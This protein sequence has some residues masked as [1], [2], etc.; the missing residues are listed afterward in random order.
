MKYVLMD[1]VSD[2][3]WTNLTKAEQEQWLG[4]Y[5]AYMQAM[6]TAGVLKEAKGLVP[7]SAATTVRVV[8]GKTQVLDGPYADRS[9]P[10][11]GTR[12][13]LGDRHAQTVRIQHCVAGRLLHRR[14][15]RHELGAPRGG[16][17]RVQ[18][19]HQRE[20]ERRWHVDIR[21]HYLPAHGV[22]L[23][24]TAGGETVPCGRRTNERAA[25]GRVLEIAG[26]GRLEQHEAGQERSGS[27][28]PK[29]EERVRTRH[30][31]H[32]K[33]HDRFATH[34]GTPDR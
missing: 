19:I 18:R 17:C 21:S 33:R 23:A 3:G 20:R 16:R 15:K 24:D 7:A 13:R 5:R 32:G 14:K 9:A 22:L 2:A 25:E 34:A 28:D 11:T 1:Y 12:T 31:G 30:G 4:A 29:D 27:R 10:L 26:Q 6:L 8:K